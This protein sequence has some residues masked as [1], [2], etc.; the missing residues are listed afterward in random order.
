M[1]YDDLFTFVVNEVKS[2]G[3]DGDGTVVFR[4]TTISDVANEFEVWCKIK[5]IYCYKRHNLDVDLILFSDMSN[6]NIIFVSKK[7]ECG[8]KTPWDQEVWLEVC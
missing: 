1:K 8:A 4:E 2:G 5:K 7:N 3:G 6:E